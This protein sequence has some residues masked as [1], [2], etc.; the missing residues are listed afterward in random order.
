MKAR[1]GFVSNS[2]STS[3]IIDASK[4]SLEKVTNY[5][6]KLLDAQNEINDTATTLA[7]IC[8]IEKNDSIKEINKQI[9]EYYFCDKSQSSI[10]IHNGP[11]VI[12]G[13]VDDNSIPWT[14]QEGLEHIAIRRQHWG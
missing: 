8:F 5:V 11:V 7:E 6:Q 10:I 12:V 3:F 14:I 4:Y 9:K 1:N 13:S 2:S